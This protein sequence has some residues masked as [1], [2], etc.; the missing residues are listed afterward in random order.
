MKT[1]A[2]SSR[3]VETSSRSSP[4]WKWGSD[5]PIRLA[6]VCQSTAAN[7]R[8]LAPDDQPDAHQSSQ[9]LHT[10]IKMSRFS[11]DDTLSCTQ[12][13]TNTTRE[14][15][16]PVTATNI[17]SYVEAHVSI[18]Y[19]ASCTLKLTLAM[20][21]LWL[22]MHAVRKQPGAV[23]CRPSGRHVAS[24]HLSRHQVVASPVSDAR[25]VQ[26]RCV[27]PRGRP[28]ALSFTSAERCCTDGGSSWPFTLKLV[29]Y[30]AKSVLQ[31]KKL[32]EPGQCFRSA[33]RRR[34]L[35]HDSQME[36]ESEACVECYVK[37]AH[38]LQMVLV[39]T[40]T[41]F[42]NTLAVPIGTL[43]R[44]EKQEELSVFALAKRKFSTSWHRS[45]MGY[46]S[47]YSIERL[48]S[49][50]DC[51][52]P[53]GVAFPLRAVIEANILSMAGVTKIALE[54]ATYFGTSFSV[55]KQFFHQTGNTLTIFKPRTQ[56][57]IQN[58]L[59]ISW[60]FKPTIFTSTS[61]RAEIL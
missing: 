59:S 6:D 5:V 33:Q 29:V 54:I 41:G 11:T 25:Q 14:I 34:C 44:P 21:L 24:A 36:R 49:L 56:R 31:L 13:L 12:I 28:A 43:E 8:L 51:H 45:H 60:E 53:V 39:S 22:S 20:P 50:R 40:H 3:A 57:L 52:Q 15:D 42:T 9:S 55:F 61:K 2:V 26:D 7:D 48:L 17:L 4:D 58:L 23:P 18:L 32:Y 47:Q 19:R 1:F 16:K 46:R 27:A 38:C 30:I 37:N 35:G 10:E